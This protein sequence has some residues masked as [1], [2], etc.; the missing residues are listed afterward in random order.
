M[1][2]QP[3]IQILPKHGDHL[4]HVFMNR[5]SEKDH[6]HTLYEF[7]NTI[8]WLEY[9]HEK[10]AQAFEGRLPSTHRQCSMSYVEAVPSP[11]LRCAI[12]KNVLDCEI[13]S[14]L[15]AVVDEHRNKE[16]GFYADFTEEALYRLMSLTCAWHILKQAAGMQQGWRLDTS[17]GY[18]Q[19]TSDRIFWERTYRSM[20]GGDE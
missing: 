2:K 18:M 1:S 6:D 20:A 15:R 3:L 8:H 12:G 13:L 16:Q 19:D 14:Q 10:I 4:W 9:G 17:E 7:K 5:L 11:E